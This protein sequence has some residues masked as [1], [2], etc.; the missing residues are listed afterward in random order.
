MA[1]ATKSQSE[2]TFVRFIIKGKMHTSNPP[3]PRLRWDPLNDIGV[4]ECCC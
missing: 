2:I 4:M 3:K 1:Y